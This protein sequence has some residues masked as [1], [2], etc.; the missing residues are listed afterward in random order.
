MTTLMKRLMTAVL[1][2]A[3]AGAPSLARAGTINNAPAAPAAALETPG[4]PPVSS[5]PA[6]AT[7]GETAEYAAREAAAPQLGKFNGGSAVIFI[8]GGTVLIVLIIILIVLVI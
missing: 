8:G 1:L 5:A 3:F 2:L 6:G 4:E 7:G